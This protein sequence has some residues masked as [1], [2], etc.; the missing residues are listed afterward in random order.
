MTRTIDDTDIKIE[1]V[2]YQTSLEKTATSK[3]LDDD[4]MSANCDVT[5]F[6]LIDG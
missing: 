2:T 5:V 6:F 1:P 4:V 3:K